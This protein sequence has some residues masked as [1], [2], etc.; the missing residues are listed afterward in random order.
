MQEKKEQIEKE[1]RMIVSEQ[2]GIAPDLIGYNSSW[3][4]DLG[5]DSA[6][7]EEMIESVNSKFDVEISP[8]FKED[9]QTFGSF[10]DWLYS[11]RTDV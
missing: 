6:D 1:M 2:L 9:M 7:Y 11:A 5:M 8:E 3:L 10:V 4:D